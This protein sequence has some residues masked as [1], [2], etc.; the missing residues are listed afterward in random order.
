M[1]AQSEI[2]QLFALSLEELLNITISVSKKP[3][4]IDKAPGTVYVITDKEI[5]FNGYTSLSE[6]LEQ[7]PNVTPIDP[8]YFSFGGMRGNRDSNFSKV[9]LLI[10]GREVQSITTGETLIS[11]QFGMFNILR[12]EVLQ[13]PAS[14]L[15][16]A[17][18]FLG[19][20]NIITKS[21]ENDFEGVEVHTETGSD[22]TQ[23]LGIVVA[24]KYQD[25]SINASMRNWQSDMDNLNAFVKDRQNFSEGFSDF[26]VTLADNNNSYSNDSSAN[27]Y[28][29]LLSYKKLYIGSIGYE[30]RSGNG[31]EQVVLNY[32]ETEDR[33]KFNLHYLG[34][35]TTIK[36]QQLS[37]E[38]RKR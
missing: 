6:V 29:I 1:Q 15:Y 27:Q 3:E 10:N 4:S 25:I 20:I 38:Y 5:Q 8:A 2:D 31:L 12:I 13:G 33:R 11:N 36:Q 30:N 16:G 26:Q 19:I 7:I 14:A 37:L 9:L 34:Y 21:T 23:G 24:K 35:K 22:N 32:N 28:D 17:N 18:A